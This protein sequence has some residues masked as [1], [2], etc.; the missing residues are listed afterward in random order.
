[1]EGALVETKASPLTTLLADPARLAAIP[2][3]TLERLLA[4]QERYDAEQARRAY[5]EAFA[6]VQSRTHAVR[7]C[8]W[9]PQTQSKYVLLRDV[10]EMLDP[11]LADEGFA[12]SVSM[13][14]GADEGLMRFEL[15]IRHAGGHSERHH[16]DAPGDDRGMKGSPTKTALHGMRSSMTYCRRA[17]ITDV[18]DVRTAEPDDDGNASG[19]SGPGA[20][21]VTHKERAQVEAE[22]KRT[23][24]DPVRFCAWLGVDS[25]ANMRRSQLQNALATLKRKGAGMGS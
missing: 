24:S 7:E 21:P 14:S 16:L 20:E 9:N 11:I 2:V 4:L 17:L 18:W 5:F 10:K 25:V 15:L 23:G 19:S 1:M 22:L 6:R 12:Q 8:G 3:E 13:V